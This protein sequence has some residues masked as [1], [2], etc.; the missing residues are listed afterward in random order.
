MKRIDANLTLPYRSVSQLNSEKIY[1]IGGADEDSSGMYRQLAGGK[2]TVQ[3]AARGGSREGPGSPDP[4]STDVI[5]CAIRI[6]DVAF[7]FC[8]MHDLSTNK[9]LID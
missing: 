4:L 5:L 8:N 2:F 1:D 6:S 9:M 3:S 7:P